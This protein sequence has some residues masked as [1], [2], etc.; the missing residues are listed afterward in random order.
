[1]R[2]DTRFAQLNMGLTLPQPT[3]RSGRPLTVARTVGTRHGSNAQN[4]TRHRRDH[5]RCTHR[6]ARADPQ[7]AIACQH[8]SQHRRQCPEGR[9]PGHL[10]PQPVRHHARRSGRADEHRDHDDR[11]H[12]VKGGHRRDGRHDHQPK[13]QRPRRDAQPLS[14]SFV[15]GRYAQGPPEQPQE[16]TDH[17]QRQRHPGQ[18]NRDRGQCRRVHQRRPAGGIQPD[19][20]FQIAKQCVF[21]IQMHR[22]RIRLFQKQ[23]TA[24]E[25]RG[26]D[27]THGGPRLDPPQAADG[28]NR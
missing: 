14:V 4:H 7:R 15:K 24:R 22:R 2:G 19:Q 20:A 10:M 28:L 16:P 1:M 18:L 9:R 13:A 6:S 23:N 8:I 3:L 21:H 27:D 5:A 12:R 26:K 25:H 17:D 11:P